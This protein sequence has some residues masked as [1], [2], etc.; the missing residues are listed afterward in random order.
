MKTFPWLQHGAKVL[1]LHVD[2]Y[3]PPRPI[4]CTHNVT[5]VPNVTEEAIVESSYSYSYVS[6]SY[7]DTSLIDEGYGLN[8]TNATP[9]VCV[10]PVY[11]GWGSEA[12]GAECP[13][14][15]P[16]T[17]SLTGTARASLTVRRLHRPRPTHTPATSLSRDL[18]QV[19]PS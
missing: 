15:H 19:R 9:F 5:V 8:R 11:V 6:Y 16:L 12:R 7:G 13:H 2:N 4:N 18:S 10:Q 3:R 17:H 14:G 1:V